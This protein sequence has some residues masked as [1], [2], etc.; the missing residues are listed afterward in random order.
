MKQIPEP[1]HD[2]FWKAGIFYY[3]PSDPALLVRK[4]SGL[5]YTMNLTCS[6]HSERVRV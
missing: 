5:G 2:S 6:P 3:N 1:K 4:R